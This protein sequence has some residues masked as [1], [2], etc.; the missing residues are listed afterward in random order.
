MAVLR[1]TRTSKPD[2]IEA[3]LVITLAVWVIS[4]LWLINTALKQ[5][6]ITSLT[7]DSLTMFFMAFATV[8]LLVVAIIMADVRKELRGAY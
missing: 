7:I 4:V 3:T 8:V 2:L 6:V 1:P 5:T